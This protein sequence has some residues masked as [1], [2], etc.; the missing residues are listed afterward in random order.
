[1][2]IAFKTVMGNKVGHPNRKEAR[3]LEELSFRASVH[4]PFDQDPQTLDAE[5]AEFDQ[6][7]QN[8]KT[9]S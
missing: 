5:V 7:I 4:F 1:M 2:A 6:I 8:T 3:R 9:R